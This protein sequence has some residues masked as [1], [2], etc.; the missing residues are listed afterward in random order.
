MLPQ[1]LANHFIP[2]ACQR[3]AAVPFQGTLLWRGPVEYSIGK[4]K[5]ITCVVQYAGKTDENF[6]SFVALTLSFI[7]TDPIS[8]PQTSAA[9][10]AGP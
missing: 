10:S 3:E 9:S 8:R 2:H 7:L 6:G 5:R 1:D 4:L